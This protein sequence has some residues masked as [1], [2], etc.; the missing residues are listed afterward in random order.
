VPITD[1]GI[2]NDIDKLEIEPSC[3]SCN[4]NEVQVI[5]ME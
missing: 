5:P 3:E 1:F 4:A 2:F